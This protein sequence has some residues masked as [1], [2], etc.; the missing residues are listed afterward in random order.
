MVLAMLRGILLIATLGVP[1]L[2][3]SEIVVRYPRPE[4]LLDTRSSY[5]QRL[6][7]LALERA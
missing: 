5:P 4:S 1:L 6:L 7:E 2:A 3:R